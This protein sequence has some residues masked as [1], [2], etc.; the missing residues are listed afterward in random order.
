MGSEAM[1]VEG[2]PGMGSI[3][4]DAFVGMQRQESADATGAI[5]GIGLHF[6]R[7][8]LSGM[9]PGTALSMGRWT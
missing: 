5:C 1:K 8:T 6:L 7:S 2:R 4:L 3:R 9:M